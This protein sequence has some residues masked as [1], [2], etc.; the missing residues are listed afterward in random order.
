VKTRPRRKTQ[1]PF[2]RKA[3]WTEQEIRELANFELALVVK[4]ALEQGPRNPS[5]QSLARVLGVTIRDQSPPKTANPAI[6]PER[7]LSAKP[8]FICPNC[9]GGGYLWHGG[10]VWYGASGN[11]HCTNCGWQS[12]NGEGWKAFILARAFAS[13]ADAQAHGVTDTLPRD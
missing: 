6:N 5:L 3:K 13:A 1:D 4:A 10:Y 7:S 11:V 9:N 2:H 12:V 8:L